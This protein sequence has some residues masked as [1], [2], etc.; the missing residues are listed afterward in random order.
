MT[1]EQIKEK[2]KYGDYQLLGELLEITAEAAKMRF[3]RGDEQAKELLE[4]IIN[5]REE[6]KASVKA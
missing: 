5:N 1:T 6:F 4:K 3:F 2:L